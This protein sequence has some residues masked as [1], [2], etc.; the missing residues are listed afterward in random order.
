MN[1]KKHSTKHFTYDLKLL[2]RSLYK[3]LLLFTSHFCFVLHF[4]NE[5]TKKRY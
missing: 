3:D 1:N 4:Q 5:E 2:V